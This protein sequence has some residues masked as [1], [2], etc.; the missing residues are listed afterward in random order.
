[1]RVFRL[2]VGVVLVLG[3]GSAWATTALTLPPAFLLPQVT[4]GYL[5]SLGAVTATPNPASISAT[6]P[7]TNPSS[8]SNSVTVRWPQTGGSTTNP[9]TLKVA[10]PSFTGCSTV[11]ISAITVT[12]DSVSADNIN[13]WTGACASAGP[14]TTTGTMVAGGQEGKPASRNITVQLHYVFADS[15]KYVGGTCPAT[16]TYTVTAQ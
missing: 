7:D 10:A 12:C 11:P 13:S 5:V 15:W 3:A 8:S 4:V 6:D 14:L 1:M 2:I 16:L 9:W